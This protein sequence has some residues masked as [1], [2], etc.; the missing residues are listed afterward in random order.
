[1][2]LLDFLGVKEGDESRL[3]ELIS[4]ACE[5]GAILCLMHFD[6]H[7]RDKEVVEHSLVEFTSKLSKE[8]G[9]LYA[10]SHVELAE[11]K[12]G[13][14]S[15]ISEATILAEN[16]QTLLLLSLRYGPVAI[17][18]QK[19]AAIKLSLEDAQNA[20]LTASHS[21]Q[22]YTAYILEKTLSPEDYKD[23]LERNKRRVDLGKKM[24][25]GKKN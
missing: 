12:D 11:E 8:K 21:A 7:G 1:M 16:F 6:A 22:E 25:E 10:K 18:L 15:A 17:E 9:V 24:M 14:Y 19:P 3:D 2:G 20:L 13:I 5:K 4:K 23:F